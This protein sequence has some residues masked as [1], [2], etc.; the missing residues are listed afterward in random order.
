M[1]SIHS[2]NIEHLIVRRKNF[3]NK[4]E[5]SFDETKGDYTIIEPKEIDEI[6]D[7]IID[8][9]LKHKDDIDLETIIESLTHIGSAPNILY[10][11]NGHFAITCDGIQT[12]SYG[13]EPVDVETSF[14]IEK[15]HWFSTIREALNHF[16]ESYKEEM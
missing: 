10:D 9:I 15:E 13:D 4:Y 5:S 14:Y 1:K 2:K 8:Y 11:D 12:I 7:E 3:L 16:L 6:A